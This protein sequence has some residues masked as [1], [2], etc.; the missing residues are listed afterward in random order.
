MSRV[1]EHFKKLSQIPHCSGGAHALR[2]FLIDFASGYGYSADVDKGDNILISKEYPLL[3]LQAHYDMVCMGDAPKIEVYEEDGLLRAKNASLG[4]DNGMA[5]AM[6]MV[7][8][9]DGYDLEFVLTS[10]EEIGLIGAGNIEFDLKSR[11]ML[12]LDSE[13]EGRLYIGCAGGIDLIAQKEPE[14]IDNTDT[15]FYEVSIKDLPGGHSGVDIDKG[16]P[17]AIK[18]LVFFIQKKGAS[19]IKFEG[20]E[21]SNSIP[22][23]AIAQI[24]SR[25]KIESQGDIALKQIYKKCS[26]PK[27]DIVKIID[28]VAH[29]VIRHNEEFNI[30]DI[31]QNLAIVYTDEKRFEIVLSIR[32]MNMGD[33]E[34]QAK[35]MVSTFEYYGF[36]VEKK[37]KY[38]AWKPEHNEFTDIVERSLKGLFEDVRVEAIHAGLECG[39]LKQKYPDILFASIGPTIRYPHSIREE[40]DIDSIAKSFEVVKSIIAE[41]KR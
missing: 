11:Y 33:L 14:M 38:P 31:S 27:C 12:N 23:N 35:K 20:G 3:A 30:P 24:S 18:E 1:I 34:M 15:F 6:M 41:V 13:E 25:Y 8:I 29:G 37:D 21:R 39:V 32:A 26:K 10:D 9:E 5:I 16:I 28:A 19:I 40:V 7:L 36:K 2:D 4:A 17:N 22:V